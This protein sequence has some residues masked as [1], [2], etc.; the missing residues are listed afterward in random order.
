[1]VK[2][3]HESVDM[4]RINEALDSLFESIR[5]PDVRDMRARELADSSF[6]QNRWFEDGFKFTTMAN[7]GRDSYFGIGENSFSRQ[8]NRFDELK[9]ISLNNHKRSR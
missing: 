5:M 8:R 7:Y 2:L 6:F 1:M 3:I 9:R 4:A